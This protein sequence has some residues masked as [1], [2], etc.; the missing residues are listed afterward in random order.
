MKSFLSALGVVALF[1][2]AT[3]VASQDPV[4]QKE[5]EAPKQAKRKVG[6]QKNEPGAYQGY[7]LISPLGSP[8]TFLIDMQ[9]RIVRTWDGAAPPQLCA[10][11][12]PNGNLLRPCNKSLINFQGTL[13]RI[14]EF[15][16][17]GDVVWDYK[18]P[19]E[20]HK[21]HHDI[22]KLSNGNVLVVFYERKTAEE[23]AAA[24]RKEAGAL[25]A[26]GILELRPNGKDGA[27]IV[28]QWHLWDHLIQ[29]HDNTKANFGAVAEH[30]ELVDINGNENLARLLTKSKIP[31]PL[32]GA[33][34]VPGG[35]WTHMNGIAYH[36]ELDQIIV[37]VHAF[38]EFWIIDHSTSTAEAAGHTGGKRSKGGDL[39]YRW[40]N[41]QAYRAGT[42][43]DRKLF[44][45]H[46]AHWIP[47]GL[48]GA[49]NV[50]IFNNGLGRPGGGYSSIEEVILPVDVAGAYTRRPGAAFGPEKALWTYSNEKKTDFYSPIISGAQRL[51]NGNT[52]ICAGTTGSVFEVTPTG[53]LVWGYMNP[54]GGLGAFAP[55]LFR[56][57]RYGVDDPALAGRT[58]TAGKTIE[59]TLA[60]GKG[61]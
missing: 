40:G 19:D 42:E 2:S 38:S 58:L 32:V 27:D 50:L 21:P 48:P 54:I 5:Q 26:D 59:E 51:A 9:G 35:N 44:H 18:F 41:P 53:D 46:N 22:L 11:L 13:G 39:L 23:C 37:S 20:P 24:G 56:A 16:W 43:A 47:K 36:S 34:G 49:G 55:S 33:G 29:D 12:L 4:P 3:L 31:N 60:G 8:K 15:N 14:Q 28:W 7:T 6:V 17:D 25:D 10:N 52:M 30:P 45:Q 1:W 57:Y 61:K